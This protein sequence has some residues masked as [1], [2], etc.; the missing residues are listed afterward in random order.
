LRHWLSIINP[1]F[2][3]NTQKT[4]VI[5][6]GVCELVNY[7]RPWNLRIMPNRL[8]KFSMRPKIVAKDGD[9]ALF[10]S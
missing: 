9:A 8:R 2:L 7:F 4:C 5:C 10:Q 6:G 1:L 3:F